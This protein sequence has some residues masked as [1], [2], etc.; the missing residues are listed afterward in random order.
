MATVNIQIEDPEQY[1]EYT[2]AGVTRKIADRLYDLAGVPLSLRGR[3][4][5]EIVPQA[6]GGK[7]AFIQI[8]DYRPYLTLVDCRPLYVQ[9]AL[10][11]LMGVKA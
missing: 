6:V 7:R 9:A 4:M 5:S 2:F 1:G 11:V 3:P 8:I 10:D